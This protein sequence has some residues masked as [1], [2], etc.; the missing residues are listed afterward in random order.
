MGT[1]DS[2]AKGACGPT[3]QPI[4]LHSLF[5]AT[6]NLL[7]I[8]LADAEDII[9]AWMTTLYLYFNSGP[10]VLGLTRHAVPLLLGTDR[11]KV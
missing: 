2:I 11:N 5:R 3:R 7:H 1:H 8:R 4:E 6:P 9:G 10:T